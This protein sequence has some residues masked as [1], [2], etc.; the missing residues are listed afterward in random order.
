MA[1]VDVVVIG[2]GIS[3]LT[4]ARTL[5][6][7]GLH[8]RLLE[9]APVCGGVIRTDRVGDFVID[10]GPDTL[11]AHKPAALAPGAWNDVE[12]LTRRLVRRPAGRADAGAAI[13]ALVPILDHLEAERNPFAY[14]VKALCCVL[15]ARTNQ[16]P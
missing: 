15:L 7:R 11:L 14:V 6:R 4:A 9:R 10:T 5:C 3:G 8:V 1:D 13:S 12:R 16:A 2:G